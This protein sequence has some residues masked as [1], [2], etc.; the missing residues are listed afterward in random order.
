MQKQLVLLMGLALISTSAHAEVLVGSSSANIQQ[1]I[2]LNE[3]DAL[4]FATII[5]GN[6]ADQITIFEN[7]SSPSISAVGDAIL[8]G[9]FSQGKFAISG[10][11]GS[12][13]VVNIDATTTLSGPGD[14]MTVDNLSV[15]DSTPLLDAASGLSNVVVGGRLNVNANQLPGLYSGTYNV[16]VTYQ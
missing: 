2:Q 1:A 4:D 15:N 14:T 7:M 3:I 9:A 16:T 12:I 11:P 5:P 10:V 8:S 13:V 6:N